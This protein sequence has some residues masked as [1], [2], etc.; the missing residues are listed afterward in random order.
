MVDVLDRAAV[1]FISLRSH[2]NGRGRTHGPCPG[3]VVSSEAANHPRLRFSGRDFHFSRNQHAQI[4]VRHDGLKGD[5]EDEQEKEPIESLGKDD[6][7][8]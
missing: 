3:T 8:I 4:F 6:F 2:S 5:T 1:L 7:P